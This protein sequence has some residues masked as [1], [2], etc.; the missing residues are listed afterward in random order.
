MTSSSAL[1][2]GRAQVPR[3]QSWAVHKCSGTRAG[4]CTSAP[5]PELG[6][7][8]VP[9]HQSWAVHTCP[10]T[11]AGPCTSLLDLQFSGWGH[12]LC[13]LSLS[14]CNL[15]DTDIKD[16]LGH[17]LANLTSLDLS[18]NPEITGSALGGLQSTRQLSRL[19]LKGCQLVGN[20]ALEYVAGSQPPALEA[21]ELGGCVALRFGGGCCAAESIA[22]LISLR[23]L[24][25]PDCDVC[26]EAVE[27]LAVL[28][29]LRHLNLSNCGRITDI[30][31]KLFAT[32]I[33]LITLNLSN[34]GIHHLRKLRTGP[35]WKRRAAVWPSEC[36]GAAARRAVVEW[37]GGN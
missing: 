4:P 36:G 25:M 23:S 35:G 11:R 22:Q 21:L 2:L 19:S 27:K 7:A 12:T 30:G 5:A 13:T 3:H 31:V 16:L 33:D 29:N 14:A 24:S 20:A 6:R 32:L 9:R 28:T 37:D 26:D 8:Q 10:G 17:D 1:A 18:G 34:L 15:A